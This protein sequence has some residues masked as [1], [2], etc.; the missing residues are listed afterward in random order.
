M[1]TLRKVAENRQSVIFLYFHNS[2]LYCV[3]Y[4]LYYLASIAHREDVRTVLLFPLPVMSYLSFLLVVNYLT[5][6]IGQGLLPMT[7]AFYC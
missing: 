5:R 2:T 7:I 4:Y 1:T 6:V 3:I